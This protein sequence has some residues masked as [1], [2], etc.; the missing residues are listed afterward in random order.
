MP[1]VT[2][3]ITCVFILACLLCSC[4]STGVVRSSLDKDRPLTEKFDAD[5]AR[6]TVESMADSMMSFPPVVEILVVRRPVLDLEPVKNSTMDHIDTI[7]ITQALRTRLLRSGK[8]RFKDR[9]T[10]GTD[11]EIMIE[12]SELGLVERSK[13]VRAGNQSATELYLYGRISQDRKTSGRR[14][15]QYYSIILNLKDLRSGELIWSEQK[16]IRKEKNRPLFVG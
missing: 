5:D 15:D 16:E 13:A 2:A 11:I 12:E 9:S 14:V 4:A 1:A 7:A 10:S 3:K 8:F 6:I